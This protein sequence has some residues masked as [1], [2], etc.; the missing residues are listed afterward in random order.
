MFIYF[1]ERQREH[2]QGRGRVRERGRHRIW[3]RLLALSCQ[4][5]ARC[6]AWTHELWDHDLSQSQMLNQLSHPGTPRNLDFNKSARWFWHKLE[7]K[8]TFLGLDCICFTVLIMWH[9]ISYFF[10]DL[11]PTSSTRIK[12]LRRDLVTKNSTWHT[13]DSQKR[14]WDEWMICHFR[15]G[16]THQNQNTIWSTK[17]QCII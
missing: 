8:N 9:Y 10:A 13:A 14:F 7:F 1:W 4:H 15:A 16:T 5:R 12:L 11:L 6:G 2:E 3:S 17:C